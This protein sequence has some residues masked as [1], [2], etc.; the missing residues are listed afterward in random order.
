V[1][2]FGT[3]FVGD[4]YNGLNAPVPDSDPQDCYGE[5][6]AVAGI[7]AAQENELGFLGVAPEATIGSYRI[8]GCQGTY[9]T[10]LL[11][12]ALYQAYDDDAD[13]IMASLMPNGGWSGDPVSVAV[14]R[15]V[16]NGVPCI[17]GI[18]DRGTEG[19]FAVSKV[20]SGKGAFAVTSHDLI[21][22]P[23]IMNRAEAVVDNGELQVFG[24]AYSLPEAWN[25]SALPL[26]AP[27]GETGEPVGC[28][29][30]PQDI[31]DLSKYIVLLREG[32]CSVAEK[33]GIAVAAG[34]RYVLMYT[35]NQDLWG[36]NLSGVKGLLAFGLLSP[37]TGEALLSYIQAG[38][39]VLVTILPG[40][41]GPKVLE[42]T[43]N[44]LSPGTVTWSS[45]WGPTF[46]LEHPT[47][48]GAPGSGIVSLV[49]L[50]KGSGLYNSFD[51]TAMASAFV[52]GVVALVAEARGTF[53]PGLIGSLLTSTANPQLDNDD[54]DQYFL[55]FLSPTPLQGGGLIQAYDAAF[56]TTL[57]QP[58][59]LSFNDTDHF[60]PSRNFTITNLGK[61]ETSYKIK[62]ISSASF[63]SLSLD[64][65]TR[66]FTPL[67][68]IEPSAKLSFSQ[69]EVTIG[70]GESA[71]IQVSSTPPDGLNAS[72]IPIWSGWITVNGTDETSLSLPYQGM[73]G[74]FRD[75]Y[76]Q[77]N[78]SVHL[79]PPGGFGQISENYTFILPHPESPNAGVGSISSV[80]ARANFGSR[81]MHIDIVPLT[82]GT[83]EWATEIR[84]EKSIGEITEGPFRWLSYG[85][86]YFKWN[87]RLS[88]GNYW[89]EG[90]YKLIFWALHIFGDES[91]K[92]DW[93]VSESP[94]FYIKYEEE[95]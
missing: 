5:G 87:G 23:W 90:R 82:T 50:A 37:V 46:D 85:D 48:F 75:K 20:A 63:Y 7:I 30:Y 84:G 67:E 51:G 64:A 35:P 68:F 2:G 76:V 57:L 13:I 66:T 27:Y 32:Y 83:P 40:T 8:A 14:E 52:A 43:E 22:K 69:D 91:R 95:E 25:D 42:H 81:L 59:G 79:L 60:I 88:N 89:P 4:D 44:L 94:P 34:A 28:E 18:G 33:V 17:G 16:K 74:S 45:A 54:F 56:S 77:L 41:N 12:A 80:V 72:R 38:S 19:P 9:T 62:Y 26:W 49:P 47:Q 10:D 11:I 71:I 36:Y 53:E 31:P 92:D 39:Q 15:I 21:N 73:V 61:Y 93:D 65:I 70:A 86:N 6:T 1:V 55:D 58:A 78:N 29:S 24:S 3:D